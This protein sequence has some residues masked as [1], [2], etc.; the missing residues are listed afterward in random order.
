MSLRRETAYFCSSFAEA[1]CDV[2]ETRLRRSLWCAAACLYAELLEE[3]DRVLIDVDA[4]ARK[5]GYDPLH[6]LGA[7][8]WLAKCEGRE[9]EKE[10]VMLQLCKVL[11]ELLVMFYL[12]ECRDAYAE[13]SKFTREII[14][15]GLGLSPGPQQGP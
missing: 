11:Y 7:L 5:T 1:V 12:G 8:E 2:C 6:V 15:R 10:L 13:W 3:G 4:F 14:L 9:V